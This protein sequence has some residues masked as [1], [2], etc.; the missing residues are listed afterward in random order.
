MGPSAKF[1]D[2]KRLCSEAQFKMFIRISAE[3][4]IHTLNLI[5]IVPKPHYDDINRHT[6]AEEELRFNF[7][8][9][10]IKLLKMAS[11]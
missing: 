6:G 10:C 7:I 11:S 1:N 2:I 3:K 8:P 5:I 9:S 4:V